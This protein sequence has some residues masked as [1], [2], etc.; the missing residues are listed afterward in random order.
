M[1]VLELVY[2]SKA[3]ATQRKGRAGRLS[4]VSSLTMLINDKC[5]M[6]QGHCLRLYSEDQLTRDNLVPQILRSSLDDVVLQLIRVGLDPL[7]FPFLDAPD[8]DLLRSSIKM[9]SDIKCIK[10]GG[11]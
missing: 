9:L 2:I 5:C 6:S 3:S 1:N 7:S 4:K 8:Y 10:P 11:E